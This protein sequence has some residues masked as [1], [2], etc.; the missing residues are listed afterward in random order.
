MPSSLLLHGLLRIVRASGAGTSR[1]NR[2]T[3][4]A[5][6]CL[7]SMVLVD[8]CIV[9]LSAWW[10]SSWSLWTDIPKKTQGNHMLTPLIKLDSYIKDDTIAN[11]FITS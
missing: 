5:I 7:K 4:G 6:I 8:H 10:D 9:T 2:G 11:T 3:S 1:C